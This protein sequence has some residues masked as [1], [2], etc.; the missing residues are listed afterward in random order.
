MTRI[1]PG[2]S[3]RQACFAVRGESLRQAP[4]LGRTF[5]R[6]LGE[7][8][9]P[10]SHLERDHRQV[11]SLGAGLVIVKPPQRQT[12]TPPFRAEAP[13]GGAQAWRSGTRPRLCGTWKSTVAYRHHQR[14]PHRRLDYLGRGQRRS[15]SLCSLRSCTQNLPCSAPC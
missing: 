1:S 2:G 3:H 8:P 11:P 9:C 12:L 15:S 5:V 14:S 6:F 10:A 7:M 4:V 13:L